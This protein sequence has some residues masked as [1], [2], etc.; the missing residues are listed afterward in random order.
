MSTMNL[1]DQFKKLLPTIMNSLKPAIV[2]GRSDV[3]RDYD[4]MMPFLLEGFQSRVGEMTEMVAAVY[5]SNFSAEDLRAIT[6]FYKTPAG[7]RLL[8]KMP[9]VTAQTMA[10]GQE[11]GRQIG[12]QMKARIIDEMRKKGHAI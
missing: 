2:Q 7:Q 10:V 1:P 6:A 5:A 9:T 8:Q 12:E 3:A 4:A 11:F